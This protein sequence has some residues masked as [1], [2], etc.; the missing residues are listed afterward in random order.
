MYV[1]Y[2]YHVRIN[3]Y[4]IIAIENTSVVVLELGISLGPPFEGFGLVSLSDKRTLNFI[5]TTTPSVLQNCL[6]YVLTSSL[7]FTLHPFTHSQRK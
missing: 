3:I 5:K 7:Y 1:L 2:N 6:I 4:S